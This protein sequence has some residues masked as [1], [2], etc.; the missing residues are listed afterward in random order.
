[1][2]ILIGMSVVLALATGLAWAQQPGASPVD[3]WG[4]RMGANNM[5]QDQFNKL[6]DYADQARRLTKD[7][8]DKGKTLADLLAE[9]KTA[10]VE[11]AKSLP[12][13]CEVSDAVLA[14]EGPTTLNGQTVDTKTYEVACANGLGYFLVKPSIGAPYGFSCLAAEATRQA[15]IAA[16]RAPGTGC[17]LGANLSP[18]TIVTNVLSRSGVSCMV[19]KITSHGQ[20]AKAKIEYTEAACADGKGFILL[21]ALPGSQMTPQSMSCKDAGNRGIPCKLTESGPVVTKQTFIDAL[22]TNNIACSASVDKIHVI[23]QETAKKRYVVEFVCPE[24]PEGLV[25]FIPLADSTAPFESKS[26]QDAA[27]LRAMCKLNK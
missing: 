27:K 14:A 15:D 11:V 19:S 22:K 7:D 4:S 3:N 21:T 9:D 12:L 6:G 20:N 8:K 17:K 10:A 18:E 23:G 13:S 24:R 2:R 16:G 5:T 26:C 1:M 25:A